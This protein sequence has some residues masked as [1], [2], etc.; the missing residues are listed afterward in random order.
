MDLLDFI[1]GQIRNA[2]KVYREI[3]GAD[4]T[5]AEGNDATPAAPKSADTGT[6]ATSEDD[7]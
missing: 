7:R 6:S 3:T 5:Q 4:E 2:A 1:D